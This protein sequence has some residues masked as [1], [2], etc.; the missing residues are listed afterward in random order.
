MFDSVSYMAR[1]GFVEDYFR[2]VTI[3]AWKRCI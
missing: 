2:I 3:K 1:V